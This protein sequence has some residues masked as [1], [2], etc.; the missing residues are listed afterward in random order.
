MNSKYWVVFVLVFGGCLRKGLA[1]PQL[2]V[3]CFGI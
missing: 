1:N 3:S 2:G